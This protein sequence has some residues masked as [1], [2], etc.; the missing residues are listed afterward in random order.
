MKLRRSDDVRT[1][2]FDEEGN[3]VERDDML[4]KVQGLSLTEGKVLRSG[5]RKTTARTWAGRDGTPMATSYGDMV[6]SIEIKP[7]N[8]DERRV[9]LL[10]QMRE[11]LDRAS[12]PDA[13][14][15]DLLESQRLQLEYHEF[16]ALL[17]D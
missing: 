14:P 4:V 8:A 1:V 17:D 3:E 2:Y 10:Q 15:A 9:Q 12:R 11:A 16:M 7:A 13:T 5:H 6:T